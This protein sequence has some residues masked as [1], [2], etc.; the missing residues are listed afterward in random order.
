MVSFKAIASQKRIEPLPKTQE[1]ISLRQKIEADLASYPPR[2]KPYLFYF[3]LQDYRYVS[4]HGEAGVP[5]A[6]VIKLPILLEYFKR[7]E[8]G[9]MTPDTPLLYQGF[10]QSEGS[11]T[12]Q[13]RPPGQSLPAR[14]VAST[15]IQSSDNSCTNMLI[16]HLGGLVQLNRRF[17]EMGLKH[18]YIANWLPDLGGSNIISM[19]DMAM[20]LYNLTQSRYLSPDSHLGALEI[21]KGTHNRRLLPALLPN[22]VIVAHKTGDIGTSLGNAGLVILPD[23]RR[24]IVALQVE[25]PFNDYSAKEMIQQVSKRIYDEVLNQS[26]LATVSAH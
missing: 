5:A 26:A 2:L 4:I 1:D 19:E 24:Y 23:G 12:L 20:V 14:E 11:G 10:Q 21:L 15:M 25:R 7:I 18:T 6:S 22:D 13:Y 17:R 16:Y 8:E 9:R 3:N